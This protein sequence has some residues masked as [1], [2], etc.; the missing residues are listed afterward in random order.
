MNDYQQQAADFLFKHS[1]KFSA[2]LSNTKDPVWADGRKH[3]HFIATFERGKNRIS[4][5]FFDSQNNFEK[6][7]ETLDAYSVLACCSSDINCPDT[8]EE[9]CSEFGYPEHE[10]YSWGKKNKKSNKIFLACKKQ[11]EKLNKLF[12]SNEMKKDL[13]EIC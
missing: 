2:K 4:F 9:F 1:I 6:E 13:A 11:S 3:N 5:D 8:F 10:Q 7:I 12:N